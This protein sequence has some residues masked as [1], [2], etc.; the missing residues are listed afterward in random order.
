MGD[1]DNGIMKHPPRF[2]IESLPDADGI[3]RISG[4]EAHHMRDVMRLKP[5]TAVELIDEKGTRYSGTISDYTRD[6]AQ[7]RVGA[8]EPTPLR[9]PLIVAP[10][11][12]KGPRMDFIVEKAAEL[13]ATEL[14][15]IICRRSVGKAPGDERVMRW[16]RLATA[17]SKQSLVV[18]PL[19]VCDARTFDELLRSAPPHTLAV[20][21]SEGENPMHEVLSRLRPAGLLIASGPE[22]DF[23]AGEFAAALA[24]GFVPVGLGP[25]RLRSETA[26]VAALSI[27]NQMLDRKSS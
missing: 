27:A 14:W 20:I 4:T 24:A 16:R 10:A 22:G 21:C 26:A 6:G 11:I 7:V 5:G 23:E 15:P 18:P 3:V 8:S 17:A 12:I 2:A 1:A 19:Q 25:G 13:G 9:P